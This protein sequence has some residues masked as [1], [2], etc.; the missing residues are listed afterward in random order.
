M[1]RSLLLIAV[2]FIIFGCGNE[3]GSN[4]NKVTKR[5]TSY[6]LAI[7]LGYKLIGLQQET[8]RKIVIKDTAMWVG[9]DSSTMKKEYSDSVYYNVSVMIPIRDS[10]SAISVGIPW[11]NKDTVVSRVLYASPMYVREF[12]G[13]DSALAQLK[14]LQDTTKQKVDTT[15][16]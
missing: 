9:K 3:G 8:V 1:K 5:D 4:V 13:Y 10:Q 14:R 7:Y 16:K 11:K 6:P 2:G 12:P 15:K